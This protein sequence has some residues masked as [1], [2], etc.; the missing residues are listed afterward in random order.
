MKKIECIFG[1]LIFA[2]AFF[3][4]SQIASQNGAFN[5]SVTAHGGQVIEGASTVFV[6]NVPAARV[7]DYHTCPA[8]NT[9]GSPHVG[10][11]ILSGSASVLIEG[12]AAARTTDPAYCEG[13][14][15][16]S[17]SGGCDSVIIGD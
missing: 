11:P 14:T 6:C 4:P 5:G 1:A 16:D 17:I 13:P 3:V 9:D 15:T 8:K 7:G 10:G 2:T 12:K